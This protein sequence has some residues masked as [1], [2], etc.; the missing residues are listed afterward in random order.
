MGKYLFIFNWEVGLFFFLGELLID[1]LLLVDQL[2]E[3]GC[4]K[5][6]V[7]MIICL[8][9]VIVELYMVDV[10]CC[11]FYFIIEL[12]GVILEVFCLLIGNCIYG[13]DDCQFIC[14]WNCYFQLID[15]VDFSLCKVL[16]NLDLFELFSWSE[17]QFL[18][19]IEGFVIWCIGY[20]CWLCNVVVVLGNVLWSN[21]VIMVL[22]SCK[23]EY[24]FFD[25]YIEW[26]I[27]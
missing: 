20:L 22:E 18:K 16:Y 11:I 1:L 6:V 13:C 17:V 12:E 25:E 10:W 26:V 27:V 24:L 19:V 21:V 23:G 2:V 4:G 15:E 3:E 8:I 5:C 7:C 9:G 14:L